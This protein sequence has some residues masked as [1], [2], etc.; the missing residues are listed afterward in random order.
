MKAIQSNIGYLADIG[1]MSI[2]DCP[3]ISSFKFTK[4]QT[5]KCVCAALAVYLC[6]SIPAGRH[7]AEAPLIGDLL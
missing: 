4:A 6:C 7:S 3:N 1:P 2:S 5:N